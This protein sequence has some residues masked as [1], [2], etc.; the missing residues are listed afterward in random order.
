MQPS[1]SKG[2]GGALKSK[3]NEKW[4]TQRPHPQPRNQ[5]FKGHRETESEGLGGSALDAGGGDLRRLWNPGIAEEPA[6]ARGARAWYRM[7]PPR[8]QPPR[9]S[10]APRA[11]AEAPCATRTR[12]PRARSPGAGFG[13]PPR[14][15]HLSNSVPRSR[16]VRGAL[17]LFR[18]L[19]MLIPRPDCTPLAPSLF[20]ESPSLLFGPHR[21]PSWDSSY[22]FAASSSLHLS[23][24]CH[25]PLEKLAPARGPPPV[26][27]V[28][29]PP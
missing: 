27:V 26:T 14:S 4:Q 24:F 8:R 16:A 22:P 19:L 28:P 20:L 6:G 2:E 12:E 23:F 3:R 25:L 5:Q 17:F 18:P 29:L 9:A 10:R 13:R 21:C 1:G 7:A 11:N 15:R